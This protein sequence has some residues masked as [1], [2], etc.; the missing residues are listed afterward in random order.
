MR[1]SKR[2]LLLFANAVA[3][4]NHF[5]AQQCQSACVPNHHGL[6]GGGGNWVHGAAI[7]LSWF[8]SDR[9]CLGHSWERDSR[10]TTISQR[11]SRSENS[12]GRG[13]GEY[14]PR[15]PWITWSWKCIID[16]KGARGTCDS[17]EVT[18]FNKWM[19]LFVN[20]CY[21]CLFLIPYSCPI[22]AENVMMNMIS[23]TVF[24]A[25]QKG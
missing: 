23:I 10:T 19:H 12:P 5:Y 11:C 21:S 8:K 16:W 9:T 20:Q 14:S 24:S 25:L 17:G 4:K 3:E 18:Q 7:S 22:A 15:K 1:F 6:H 13:V 2:I